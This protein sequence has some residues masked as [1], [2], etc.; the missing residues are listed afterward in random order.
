[1]TLAAR[2]NSEKIEA[3]EREVLEQR[4]LL[5]Q[6]LERYDLEVGL[7]Q[8]EVDKF[9]TKTQELT[10]KVAVLEQRLAHVE[11]L[12]DESRTR[13]WQVWLAFLGAVLSAT[14]ALVIALVRK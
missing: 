2:T 12:L 14:I 10:L 4:H 1:M 6:F 9:A 11:K 3:A 13:R 5:K 7:L 8:S